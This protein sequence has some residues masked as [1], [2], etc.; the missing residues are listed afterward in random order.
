MLDHRA[1]EAP[2]ET[3]AENPESPRLDLTAAN[4][5]GIKPPTRP[6]SAKPLFKGHLFTRS[7]TKAKPQGSTMS[8]RFS[9]DRLAAFAPQIPR[10][11]ADIPN[12]AAARSAEADIDGKRL[13]IGK[14]IRMRGEIS[15]CERLLVE[16][17]VDASLSDV[18]TI[19]V[20]ANGYFKGNAEVD[21]ASIAGTFEGNLKV[22]GH[23]EIAPSGVVKG[24]VSYKTIAVANGGRL[25]GTIESAD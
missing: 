7:L 19:E 11:V 9:S 25:L 18:K 23:L 6:F 14:Q 16:G 15:G 4:P 10:R 8:E 2:A 24:N 3:P 13:V 20:T 22:C 5:D 17:H 1:A 21:V 12:S